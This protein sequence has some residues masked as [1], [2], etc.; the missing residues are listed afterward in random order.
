M[1]VTE[2]QAFANVEYSWEMGFK[3]KGFASLGY[4][5]I[6]DD[7]YN[8]NI[9]AISNS[10]VSKFQNRAAALT[11][12]YERF[13]LNNLLYPSA[14][15]QIKASAY[16]G[17]E[18]AKTTYMESNSDATY[19]ARPKGRIEALWKNYFQIGRNF[20]FGT[21]AAGMMTIMHGNRNYLAAMI[22]NPEFAPMPSFK[23][24]FNTAFRASNYLSAGVSPVWSPV[25]KL[26]IRGDFFGYFPVRNE[27]RKENGNL[28]Y[29][30]WFRKA[31]FMGEISAVYNFPFASLSV[32][33]NYLSYPAR[34]WNVGVSFGWLIQ[35]PRFPH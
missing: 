16:I 23:N 9:A 28:G 35:A 32:Y 2:S 29:D 11:F 7:F 18:D 25:S 15:S 33:C 17:L 6:W 20:S 34:N 12:G 30:G 21:Y 5:Y 1:Y 26:Q 14:G 13:T 19:V 24:Y 22:S 4:G 27:I 31:E 3:G 10:D 8:K